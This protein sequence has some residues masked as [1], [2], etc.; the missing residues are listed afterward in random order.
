[1]EDNFKRQIDSFEQDRSVDKF[2]LDD[3][4]RIQ[5]D[6]YFKWAKRS[7]DASLLVNITKDALEVRKA[8]IDKAVRA[9]PREFGIEKVTNEAL[10]NA[11]TLDKEYRKLTEDLI[12]LKY[13][14]SMLE[15]AVKTMEHKKQ[16]LENLV[17]LFLNNYY[18]EPSIP[19]QAKENEEVKIEEEQRR[20]LNE[21]RVKRGG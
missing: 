13:E 9:N 12:Q 1:M 17:K 4:W 7:V 21:R 16:S 3:E 11:A 14:E 8:Q 15:A 19:K 20:R 6:L 5:S 18:A 10:N 2:A